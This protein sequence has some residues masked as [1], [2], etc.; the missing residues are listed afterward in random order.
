MHSHATP[1][2]LAN[3]LIEVRQDLID[4]HHGADAW[5]GLLAQVLRELLADPGLY[6]V[7]HY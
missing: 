1:R 2:G 6:K 4:T 3:V 7:E 5:A